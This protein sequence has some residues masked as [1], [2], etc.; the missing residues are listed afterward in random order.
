MFQT[1]Q[2]DQPSPQNGGNHCEGSNIQYSSYKDGTLKSKQYVTL[3]CKSKYT[4]SRIE[5]RFSYFID[6]SIFKYL[7]ILSICDIRSYKGFSYSKRF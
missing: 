5:I 3:S 4:I 2:C 1:R 7:C 6:K